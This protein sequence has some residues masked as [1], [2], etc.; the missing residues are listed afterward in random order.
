MRHRKG[1]CH[2]SYSPI[3]KFLRDVAGLTVSR[4]QLAK[5]IGEASAALERPYRELLADLPEQGRLSVDETSHKD[6]RAG[7]GTRRP[8]RPRSCSS[9]CS[10]C[11]TGCP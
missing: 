8:T 6:R 9:R 4:G 11:S 7:C 1:V 10:G 3:R 2:A 5:V